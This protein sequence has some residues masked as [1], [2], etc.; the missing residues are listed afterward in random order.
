MEVEDCDTKKQSW[1]TP[2]LVPDEVFTDREEFL[3][4]FYQASLKAATRRTKSMV[5]MGQR[6]M[7]KT[8]IL[9]RVVNRLFTDQDPTD[10]LSVVPVYYSFEDKEIDPSTF[11]ISY[12][13]N[14]ARHYVGFYLQHPEIIIDR[15]AGNEL[16]DL[17]ESAQSTHPFPDSIDRISKWLGAIEQNQVPSPE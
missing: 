11:A 12:L 9:R 3:D 7:G 15:P 4:Y 8:E 10:P 17:L 16:M 2:Q 1:I 13:E 14:F 5:L 6:R